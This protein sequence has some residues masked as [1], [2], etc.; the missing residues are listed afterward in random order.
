GSCSIASTR[1]ARSSPALARRSID[2]RGAPMI[3]NSAA[4]NAPFNAISTVMTTRGV[5]Q[6]TSAALVVGWQQY[7]LRRDD[8][9]RDRR[10]VH[11]LDLDVDAVDV[12]P[13]SGVRDALQ[14]GDDVTGHGGGLAAPLVSGDPRGVFQ[15]QDPG[16]TDA[17]IGQ[18]FRLW[19]LG[20]VLVGDTADQH[21]QHVV[22]C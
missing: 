12:D 9:G 5:S 6:S 2:A 21:R 15:R 1:R 7:R 19:P 13:L 4:T 17:P 22:E 11:A 3:A 8:H 18:A 14:H 20:L 16:E 10:T